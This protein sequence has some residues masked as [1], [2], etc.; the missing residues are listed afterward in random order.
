MRALAPLSGRQVRLYLCPELYSHRKGSSGS[1]EQLCQDKENDRGK[2]RKCLQTT[3]LLWETG[4][5]PELFVFNTAVCSALVHAVDPQPAR[6]ALRPTLGR[7]VSLP[8]PAEQQ[9]SRDGCCWGGEGAGAGWAGGSVQCWGSEQA[10]VK[11]QQSLAEGR[12]S[13]RETQ[14]LIILNDK[15]AERC[16]GVEE[17]SRRL[18][19]GQGT[20][21]QPLGLPMPRKGCHVER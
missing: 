17:P 19:E 7:L 21:L 15:E 2:K 3:L 8:E 1:R 20:E 9:L 6:L 16:R 13:C 10:T 11:T 18:L 4:R 12:G 5:T 14:T